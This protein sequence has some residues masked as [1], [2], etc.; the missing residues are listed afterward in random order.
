MR[1]DFGMARSMVYRD[2]LGPLVRIG[3]LQHQEVLRLERLGRFALR[4]PD[5]AIL[6]NINPEDGVIEIRAVGTR[7]ARMGWR[8]VL[9]K[10]ESIGEAREWMA[11]RASALS[12]LSP[13]VLEVGHHFQTQPN[14]VTARE[15]WVV[16]QI[17]S[18]EEEAAAARQRLPDAQR[19]ALLEVRLQPPSG[20][21]E[22][23][24]G[25]RA[26]LRL[27]EF[28]RFE[29]VNEPP[30]RA[31]LKDV[32]VGVGFHWQHL[33]DQKLRG[34]LEARI[35]NRGRLTAINELPLEEY[36][37]SVN[38]S[39]MMSQCPQSL[40]EAQTIA[41]RNTI[42]AT[43]DKHH[44][45]DDFDLCADDHCQCY[46]GSSRETDLSRQA[47][48]DTVGEV[49]VHGKRVADCRYSKM[50]GGLSEDAHSVWDGD[51]VPYMVSVWDGPDAKGAE[52][53]HLMP[54]DTEETA[55]A[56]I[57]A[58]PDVYCNT[59]TASDVPQYLR[60]SADYFRWKVE[61]AR[62][63]FEAS[64]GRFPLYRVGE[65]KDI[66]V[67]RRGKSG[68]IESIRV[69]G[70]ERSVAIHR[71][72]FIR[73]AFAPFFLY[74]SCFVP[75]LARDAAGRVTRVTLTGGGWGHG[76]GLC[77]I[78]AAMM[79]ERRISC[80]EILTHYYVGT[81]IERLFGRGADL[82]AILHRERS[83][84]D[85]RLGDRCYEYF[86]CYRAAR[87]PVY[88][89][90][91]HLRARESHAQPGPRPPGARPEIRFE[92]ETPGRKPVDLEAM[93]I[94]CEFLSFEPHAAA[95]RPGVE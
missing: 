48:L 21:V 31:I 64:L 59:A 69:V 70:S 66:E 11:V 61:F 89:E 80:G 79:A 94:E 56:L 17:F 34:V 35:D 73:E 84:G 60:Y 55:R 41:A 91:I 20:M 42:L 19:I 13:D 76:A 25:G 29:P 30:H 75:E 22:V 85:L 18:S 58:R 39:E 5:G 49:L 67:L 71:E 27:P 16:S 28:A 8:L 88:K 63:E 24:I 3:V 77:Q 26:P 81:R 50:C 6:G 74:S 65:L 44:H 9:V 12:D 68:R 83:A 14:P 78:G 93:Q 90:G 23:R 45:A 37:Y 7:T 2:A 53:R 47:V 82:T 86:N 33:E 10:K 92:Q 95:P 36:L 57:E 52:A 72:Y 62:E 54:A 46:R 15:A 43:M 51:R 38:A 40:L 87:C 32:I 4:H 1:E